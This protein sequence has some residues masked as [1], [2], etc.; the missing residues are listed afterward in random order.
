L[1]TVYNIKET[2]NN[3]VNTSLKQICPQK[4]TQLH[5]FLLVLHGKTKMDNKRVKTTQIHERLEIG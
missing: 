4:I 3:S 5:K 1:K 2:L